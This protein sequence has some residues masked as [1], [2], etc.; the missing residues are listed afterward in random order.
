MANTNLNLGFFHLKYILSLT[1][2]GAEY[3]RQH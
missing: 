1:G 2:S 3:V